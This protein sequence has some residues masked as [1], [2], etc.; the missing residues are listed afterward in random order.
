[1]LAHLDPSTFTTEIGWFNLEA[2]LTP[3]IFSGGC[4]EQLERDRNASCWKQAVRRQCLRQAF[5][6]QAPAHQPV[7]AI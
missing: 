4:F 5:C 7:P 1:M 3:L 6:W 2:N